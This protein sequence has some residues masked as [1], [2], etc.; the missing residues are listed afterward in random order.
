MEDWTILRKALFCIN[1]DLCHVFLVVC[2]TFGRVEAE[3]R[4]ETSGVRELF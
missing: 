1:E 3:L 2:M 4:T